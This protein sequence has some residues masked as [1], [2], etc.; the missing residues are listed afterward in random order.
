MPEI[1]S[2]TEISSL[3]YYTTTL[4]LRL[5]NVV[6]IAET[7]KVF[8]LGQFTTSF[9]SM[10]RNLSSALKNIRRLLVYYKYYTL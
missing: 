2:T 4:F 3:T 10:V 8:R 5:K 1:I 6:N 9:M 7:L